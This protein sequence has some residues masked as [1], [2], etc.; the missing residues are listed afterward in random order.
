[1]YLISL[2]TDSTLSFLDVC[3][4]VVHLTIN[5]ILNARMCNL[6]SP[7]HTLTPGEQTLEKVTSAEQRWSQRSWLGKWTGHWH[8]APS[9]RQTQGTGLGGEY[10]GYISAQDI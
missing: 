9:S 1:M 5:G 7:P 2:L 10:T 3:K 8:D 4:I 6:Q